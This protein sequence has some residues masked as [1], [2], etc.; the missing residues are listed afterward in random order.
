MNSF[1]YFTF[2]T[3]DEN[4]NVIEEGYIAKGDASRYMYFAGDITDSLFMKKMT[5]LGILTAEAAKN[6]DKK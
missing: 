4:G 6:A 3:E 1:I 2:E 5:D